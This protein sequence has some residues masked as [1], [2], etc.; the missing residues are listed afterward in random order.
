MPTSESV[1]VP[2]VESATPAFVLFDGYRRMPI[3]EAV[4][5]IGRDLESDVVVDDKRVSRHHAQLRRQYGQYV[6]YDL[7]STSG[8]TV[9]GQPIRE[10]TLQPGDVLSFAGIKMRLERGDVVDGAGDPRPSGVTR[11]LLRRRP[12]G[13]GG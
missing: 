7:D 4:V 1:Q 12:Q 5:T 6:L 11:P 8:T 3:T 10:A 13:G 2:E 9:N